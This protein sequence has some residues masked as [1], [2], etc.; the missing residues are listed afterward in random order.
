MTFQVKVEKLDR[1]P[2]LR[3][4]ANSLSFLMANR[5]FAK[6]FSQP[7]QRAAEVSV[8]AASDDIRCNRITTH[9][10]A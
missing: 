8:L 1:Y 10:R 4:R 6:A 7:E 2:I 9:C 5:R 3:N